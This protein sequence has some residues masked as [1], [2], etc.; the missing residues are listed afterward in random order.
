[1]VHLGPE[2]VMSGWVACDDIEVLYDD[3]VHADAGAVSPSAMHRV[4][5]GLRA[6][7]G[8]TR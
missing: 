8:L 7:F 6:A 2:E 5:A 1:M 4:D 3:E